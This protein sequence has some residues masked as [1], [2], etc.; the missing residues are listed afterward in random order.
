MAPTARRRSGRPGR[1]P[2]DLVGEHQIGRTRAGREAK[3]ARPAITVG[4]DSGASHVRGHEAGAELDPAEL[5]LE[6]AGNSAYKRRHAL[7]GRHFEQGWPPAIGRISAWRTTSTWTTIARA[8]SR[9]ASV[10]IRGNRPAVIA[11]R[12]RL[13]RRHGA[14]SPPPPLSTRAIAA[15]MRLSPAPGLVAPSLSTAPI[16]SRHRMRPHPLRSR[17][18]PRPVRSQYWTGEGG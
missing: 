17:G 8:I 15:W 6:G 13:S 16:T 7:P 5:E 18:A 1:R 14:A 9:S 10:A 12:C 3:L 11:V 4:A 2:L